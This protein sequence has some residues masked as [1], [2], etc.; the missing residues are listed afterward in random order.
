GDAAR[1]R[2]GLPGAKVEA[3]RRCPIDE[4]CAG[5]PPPLLA[6]PGLQAAIAPPRHWMPIPGC[7]RIAVVCPRAF[8]TIYGATFFSLARC[9][10]RLGARVDVVTPWEI[11]ADIS[12]SF[13]GSQRMGEPPD[14]SAVA[15]FMIDAPVEHYDVIVT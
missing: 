14:G 1:P 2:A 10:V 8:D 13:T 15:A 11:H 9:L 12:P 4:A 3:C 6:M 7:A 5:V